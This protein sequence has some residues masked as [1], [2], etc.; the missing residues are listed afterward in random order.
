MTLRDVSSEALMCPQNV[1]YM[2]RLANCNSTVLRALK[3]KIGGA[4]EH[5][6][7]KKNII[8]IPTM[9]QKGRCFMNCKKKKM[10]LN[11]WVD[12]S[13]EVLA[14]LKSSIPVLII[15]DR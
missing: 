9:L 15:S 7:V 11:K 3:S 12:E 10:Q 5:S 2:A 4:V 1:A 13:G 14:T 6:P 8:L